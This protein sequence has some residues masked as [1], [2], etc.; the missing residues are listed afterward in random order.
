MISE[1]KIYVTREAGETCFILLADDLRYTPAT[2]FVLEARL[3]RNSRRGIISMCGCIPAPAELRNGWFTRGWLLGG[4][5][6][7]R[8]P[9]VG[10]LKCGNSHGNAYQ[11]A[12]FVP[13]KPSCTNNRHPPP[14]RAKLNSPR[15]SRN[16]A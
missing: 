4:K 6:A 11:S 14:P 10:P 16:E 2:I 3:L 5:T 1:R 12:P 8:Y 15:G 13:R 9:S 7:V